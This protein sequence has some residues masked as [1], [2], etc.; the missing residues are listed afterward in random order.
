MQIFILLK[1][2]GDKEAAEEVASTS[3]D[4]RPRSAPGRTRAARSCVYGSLSVAVRL[5][6]PLA[7]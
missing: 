1:G 6:L 3:I 4:R 5:P 2:R 7:V